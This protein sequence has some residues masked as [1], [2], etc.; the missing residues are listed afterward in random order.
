MKYNMFPKRPFLIPTPVTTP[1]PSHPPIKSPSKDD[2]SSSMR[3]HHSLLLEES[4]PPVNVTLLKDLLVGEVFEPN[5]GR[6][7][8]GS[9]DGGI[10]KMV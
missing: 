10:N 5:S 3:S 2:S 8:S 1:A 4:S 6:S 7:G 9:K